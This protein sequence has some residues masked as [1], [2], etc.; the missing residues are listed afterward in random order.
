M[1]DGKAAR[2]LSIGTAG[3]QWLQQP[4]RAALSAENRNFDRGGTLGKKSDNFTA[5]LLMISARRETVRR[6]L[7]FGQ[8]AGR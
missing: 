7:F 4:A 5:V 8:E 1:P 3:R 2:G 6:F